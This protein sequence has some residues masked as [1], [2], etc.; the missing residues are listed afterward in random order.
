MAK[1]Q[2]KKQDESPHLMLER[3]FA[4]ADLIGRADILPDRRDQRE[5]RSKTQE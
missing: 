1:K 5:K 3:V 2:T 4:I